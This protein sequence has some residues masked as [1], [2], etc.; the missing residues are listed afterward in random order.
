MYKANQFIFYL[1]YEGR[2]RG[3]QGLAAAILKLW[4]KSHIVKIAIKYG[5]Q[6]TDNETMA[7]ELKASFIENLLFIVCEVQDI[8]DL[9]CS[10]SQ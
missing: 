10:F 9:G 6:N 2:N 5:V 8:L 1:Y 4:H 3:L 7:N